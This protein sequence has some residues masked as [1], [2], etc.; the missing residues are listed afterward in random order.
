MALCLCLGG[1]TLKGHSLGPGQREHGWLQAG[2][3]LLA[4][5]WRELPVMVLLVVVQS[6]RAEPVAWMAV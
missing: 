3:C 1:W 2:T 5:W 4:N 6:W